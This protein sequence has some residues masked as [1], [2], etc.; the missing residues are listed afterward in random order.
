MNYTGK[1]ALENFSNIKLENLIHCEKFS[2]KNASYIEHLLNII[3]R[4][5]LKFQTNN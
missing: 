3:F 4:N 1:F 2:V 5:G